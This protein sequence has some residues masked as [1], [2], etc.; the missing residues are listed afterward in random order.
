MTEKKYSLIGYAYGQASMNP[1]SS[2]APRVLR[3]LKLLERLRASGISVDDLGDA[4]TYIDPGTDAY[5]SLHSSSEEA[6]CNSLVSTFSA[7][8]Q[9]NEKTRVALETGTIPLIIGGDHSLSVGSVAAV[10]DHFG[11]SGQRIGLIWIDTHADIN[12]PETSPSKNIYGMSVAFLTGMVPGA[13]SK[14][15]RHPPAVAFDRVAYIGLRDLDPGEKKTIRERG[16]RSYTMKE[17]DVLGIAEVTRQAIQHVNRETVG[18]VVSFDLDVCDPSLV[19]GTGTPVRG[20]LTF[21]EVHVLL[22]LLAD[23]GRMLSFELMELNPRLD[24]DFRTADLA[25]SLI[26]TALGKSIL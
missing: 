11:D 26:D 5:V 20:G 4:G 3:E 22:E 13:L 23:D 16:L 25:L 2:D 12:T 15:Q 10:A 17:V 18:Y 8:R 9:L 21:R 1:G 7:C 24:T 19:P 6:L 14:L